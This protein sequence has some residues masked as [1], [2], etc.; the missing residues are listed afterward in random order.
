M[1]GSIG[2]GKSVVMTL[3]QN[4]GIPIYLCDER[5]KALYHSVSVRS[6]I[7]KHWGMDPLTSTGEVNKNALEAILSR[8]PEDK[9]QLEDIV[10]SALRVDLLEWVGKQSARWVALESAIL[11]TSGFHLLCDYT[12]CVESPVG[13]R[14]ERVAMRDTLCDPSRF[15]RL[16]ARQQ[17]ERMALSRADFHVRNEPEISLIL[18]L[19]EI[20]RRLDVL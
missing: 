5:A 2:S 13:L 1:C 14:R 15:D 3:L 20:L 4:Y 18:Q 19:E 16:E 8:S 7:R 11:F 9:A 10:H 17:D 12:L 6:T